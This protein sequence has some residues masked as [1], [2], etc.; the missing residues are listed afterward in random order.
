[1]SPIELL[2]SGIDNGNWYDIAKAYTSLT[3]DII[4]VPKH[5]DI[6]TKTIDEIFVCYN[7]LHDL[8]HKM[9]DKQLGCPS[10]E[11]ISEDDSQPNEEEPVLLVGSEI[12][13][14][15]PKK[16]QKSFNKMVL[17]TD[18]SDAD[19]E[20]V[21]RNKKRAKAAKERKLLN[22]RPKSRTYQITCALC[23]KVFQSRI[24]SPGSEIGQYCNKCLR[25]RIQSTRD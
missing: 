18:V 15:V 12:V 9:F 19:E 6:D 17:V 3:G 23:Q 4:G 8:L 10:S 20:E 22:Y 24:K 21:E 7:S 5:D 11:P 13:T 25:Q 1:M 2:K 16:H 14:E